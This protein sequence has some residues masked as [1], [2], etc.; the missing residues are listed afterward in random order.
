M[1]FGP[2]IDTFEGEAS[3]DIPNILKQLEHLEELFI[4]KN[5]TTDINYSI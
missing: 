1:H 3:H 5:H 4:P 2:D